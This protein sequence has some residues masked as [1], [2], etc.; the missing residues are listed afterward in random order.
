MQPAML[1]EI[2]GVR[3]NEGEDRRRWFTDAF[4]DLYLWID[5]KD[6]ISGFQLCYNKTFDEHALT[7]RR[8][9]GF[10][11]TR[12][13]D[14]EFAASSHMTPIMVRDGMFDRDSVAQRFEVD[15]AG[16]D[17]AVAEFVL[18]QLSRCQL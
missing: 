6:A 3:Q 17:K 15:G 1:Q 18:E 2:S 7:W 9:G 8:D 10:S 14:G 5:S 13:D 11:H 16:I 4:W 12:I